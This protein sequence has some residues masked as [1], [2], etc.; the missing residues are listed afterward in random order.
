MESL[1]LDFLEFLEFARDIAMSKNAL[2]SVLTQD[3][4]L[5]HG[6]DEGRLKSIISYLNSIKD[7]IEV[8]V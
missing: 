1:D 3:E 5:K 6:F 2:I 4:I 7:K 8:G